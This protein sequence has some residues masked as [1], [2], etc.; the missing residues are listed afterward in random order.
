VVLPANQVG[1]G[2]KDLADA[3]NQVYKHPNTGPF[4]CRQLIQRLVTAN[5]SPGYIY[6]VS[7]VFADNG[8]GVRGDMKAVIRAILMDY[9][10]RSTAVISQPGYGKIREPVLRASHTIRALHPVSASTFWKMPDTETELTQTAMKAPT[11]FNFFLP[12]YVYPGNLTTA[13]LF[14]PEM[15]VTYETTSINYSNFMESSTRTSFKSGDIKLDLST[16]QALALA[17]TTPLVDRL[18]LVL[19]ANG[20]SAGMKT[21]L[22]NYLN[23]QAT[24]GQTRAQ[25]AVHLITTSSEFCTQK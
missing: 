25:A 12:D 24:T 7:Q 16:E 9:E 23:T 3:M 18:S 15:Q 6:R 11:V 2:A 22:V 20:M 19:M 4:I 13:G 14:S 17:D 21:T 8:Q 1:G 5:P 10:A